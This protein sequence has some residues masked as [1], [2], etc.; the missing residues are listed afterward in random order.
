M[1]HIYARFTRK[2]QQSAVFHGFSLAYL[3]CTDYKATLYC[4]NI[5][6]RAMKVAQIQHFWVRRRCTDID[7]VSGAQGR[8]LKTQKSS[9]GWLSALNIGTGN[10]ISLPASPPRGFFQEHSRSTSV[11]PCRAR[12]DAV[13]HGVR[14]HSACWQRQPRRP[15]GPLRQV[16]PNPPQFWGARLDG[17]NAS[18]AAGKQQQPCYLGCNISSMVCWD[19]QCGH[20]PTTSADD[21]SKCWPNSVHIDFLKNLTLCTS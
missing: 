18:A 2:C 8:I 7:S 4:A 1:K 13:P 16:R 5:S 11:I 6:F 9:S 15:R 17:P 21:P 20:S 19:S 12:W 3:D 14:L 10:F